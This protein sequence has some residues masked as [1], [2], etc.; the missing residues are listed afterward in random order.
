MKTL[1][2]QSPI[3]GPMTV[4]TRRAVIAGLT[5][6]SALPARS[7]AASPNGPITVVHGYAPGGPT[8]TVARVIA[9]RLSNRLERQVIVDPRSCLLIFQSA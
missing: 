2:N 6:L 3:Q 5:L 8:D 7:V 1:D 9:E 4:L